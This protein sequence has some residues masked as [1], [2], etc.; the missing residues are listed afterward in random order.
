MVVGQ[1]N[2]AQTAVCDNAQNL[3]LPGYDIARGKL[4]WSDVFFGW[5][6]ERG[7]GVARHDEGQGGH[8]VG[9]LAVGALGG[10]ALAE[11]IQGLAPRALRSIFMLLLLAT[12]A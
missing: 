6:D 3:V 1:V 10:A 9:H 2:P 8:S 7:S 11:R 12:I 5:V 4:R